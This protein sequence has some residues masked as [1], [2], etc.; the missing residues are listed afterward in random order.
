MNSKSIRWSIALISITSCGIASAHPGHGGSLMTGMAS[1]MLHP[2]FGFDHLLAMLAVGAWAF[3]MGGRA[4]WL[5]P[6]TFIGLMAL[7]GAA[8]MA[9]IA[10]PQVEAGI[11]SSVLILGLLIAFAV[12]IKPAAAAALV[13]LFA[14]FHGHAHGAEM[15]ALGT[16]W[17][18]AIGFMVS[19]AALHGIGLLLAKGLDN[20]WLRAT[21]VITAAS[22]AWMM[23]GI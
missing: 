4:I 19:T 11:A 5:V 21:G 17:Q 10:L 8:G 20:R 7:A 14:I 23:V 3:Q 2:W 9:G 18:Y 13:A 22:G 6:A 15:P 16:A 1:G 12:K